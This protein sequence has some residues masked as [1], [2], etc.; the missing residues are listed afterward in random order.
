MSLRLILSESFPQRSQVTYCTFSSLRCVC[1][2]WMPNRHYTGLGM[3]AP[4]DGDV[5]P[6][7][8]RMGCE[9]GRC[10]SASGTRIRVADLVRRRRRAAP[11]SGRVT[12]SGSPLR[13]VGLSGKAERSSLLGREL[14]AVAASHGPAMCGVST[15]RAP[16]SAGRRAC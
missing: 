6:P 16:S 10:W 5:K 7:V 9:K 14:V 8:S 12:G 11:G 4:P 13:L 2:R 1:Q 3:S 15:G